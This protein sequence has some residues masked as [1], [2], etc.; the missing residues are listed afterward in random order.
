M[1]FALCIC[2]LITLIGALAIVTFVSR[3]WDHIGQRY[4]PRC[5]I[6]FTGT[7]VTLTVQGWSAYQVC[8]EAVNQEAN[9]PYDASVK[10]YHYQGTPP[11]PVMCQYT[12]GDELFSWRGTTL[13]NAPICRR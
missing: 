2:G 1:R 5:T 7:S 8:D 10:A 6:G 9:N 12:I 11:S 4:G 13:G 3:N